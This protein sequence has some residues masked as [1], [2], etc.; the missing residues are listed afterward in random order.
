MPSTA[1]RITSFS[2][3]GTIDSRKQLLSGHRAKILTD[4]A[5][6]HKN[7]EQVDVKLEIYDSPNATEI[8]EEQ[9]K[10]VEAEKREHGLP[11]PYAVHP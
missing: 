8:V 9:I 4:I 3:L 11:S 1:G 2:F 6:L 10:F 5:A 7:L